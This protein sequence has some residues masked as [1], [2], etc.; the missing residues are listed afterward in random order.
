MDDGPIEPLLFHKAINI[1]PQ[2]KLLIKTAKEEQFDLNEMFI[3]V[4][5][6]NMHQLLFLEPLLYLRLVIIQSISNLNKLLYSG[7]FG[8][9]NLNVNDPL[10]VWI[11]NDK[12][13]LIKIETCLSNCPKLDRL[14]KRYFCPQQSLS[15]LI[16][17]SSPHPDPTDYDSTIAF[18]SKHNK[19]GNVQINY[20]YS[21][22]KFNGAVFWNNPIRTTVFLEAFTTHRYQLGFRVAK[23]KQTRKSKDVFNKQQNINQNVEAEKEPDVKQA[24]RSS[25]VSVK[26]AGLNLAFNIGIILLKEVEHLSVELGKCAASV[27]MEYDNQ[28]NAR[29][30]TI[31][32]LNHFFQTEIINEVSW[33]KV[34]DFIYKIKLYLTLHKRHLLSPLLTK[35]SKVSQTI[36]SPYKTCAQ[37]LMHCVEHLTIVL[38]SPDD[39]CIHAIKFNLSAYL[40]EKKKRFNIIYLNSSSS[41][42]LTM[43]RTKEF[44]F[45]NLNMYLNEDAIFKTNLDKPTIVHNI[46]RLFHQPKINSTTTLLSICKKRGVEIAPQLLVCW[47]TIGQ[48]FL[49]HFQL[50]IFSNHF[51]SISYLAFVAVWS[52]CA[53]E[54]GIFHQGLEK[55]KAA[56]D[57]IF[58]SFSHGGYSFSCKD[59]LECGQPIFG[60]HGEAAST[61]ISL[62]ITSSY[63]YAGSKIQTPTGFCN[64]YFDNGVGYLQLCEP[65]SRHNSFEFLSVY[66]TLYLL[67]LEST[68]IKTVFSNFHSTGL[69]YIKN[70]PLDLA[71]IFS[72]GNISLFQFDG[73]Y[74][75]GCR[76]GCQLFSSF[77]RGRQRSELEAD[78]EKR[79]SVIN[80]W[81]QETNKLNTI[82][83]TYVVITDCHNDNYKLNKLKHAFYS[84]PLLAQVVCVYPTAKTCTKDDV[85]FSNDKLTFIIVLE[86]FV[87]HFSAKQIKPLLYKSKKQIWSRTDKTDTAS[88]MLFTKDYLSWLTKNYNFQVTKIHSVF[89]YKKCNVLNSIYTQLTLLRMNENTSASIKQLVKN[90]INFSAG[91]FGLNEKK[92]AKTTFR[93]MSGI[94]SKYQT[95]KHFAEPVA[96]INNCNYYIVGTARAI[97]KQ[98]YMSIAPFPIFVFIVEFGKKRLSEIMCFF[99]FFLLPSHYRHLYSN[100]DNILFVL[101]TETLDEAVDPNHYNEYLKKKTRIF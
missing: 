42:T 19:L 86:G 29:Y 32:A 79:D 100:V 48:F 71:V 15:E 96:T 101:A 57:N 97:K 6:T 16:G 2:N 92:R 33:S 20:C 70:Y 95:T 9:P 64:A 4:L 10:Q 5:K 82:K 59:Y 89:F 99:D 31:S 94:G 35:L 91:Y 47:L 90:V 21:Y 98:N 40:K 50:D 22:H 11:L 37:Q 34:F 28:F 85:L 60:T 13:G 38:F 68:Q 54:G 81:V 46:K 24:N 93:L 44:T 66:Y 7:L 61:L 65:F 83:A 62:D 41:N 88:P 45:L 87:P 55:T 3:K 18:L 51:R 74:A 58:R 39:T 36:Q 77:V 69:F 75:H 26:L 43:L 53:R 14:K 52:K 76:K 30:I 84:I 67:S 1:L 63:G 25:A 78:T 56:Y 80:L 17:L 27:W 8:G 72:N 12:G 73:A 49:D 23:L